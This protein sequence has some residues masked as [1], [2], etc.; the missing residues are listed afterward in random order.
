MSW[1]EWTSPRPEGRAAGDGEGVGIG[2]APPGS[3]R[4]KGKIILMLE[5]IGNQ[6]TTGSQKILF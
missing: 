2:K 5:N 1:G 6:Q 3:G 4:N